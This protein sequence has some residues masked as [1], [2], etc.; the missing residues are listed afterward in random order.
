MLLHLGQKLMPL[1]LLVKSGTCLVIFMVSLVVLLIAIKLFLSGFIHHLIFLFE[2]KL[3]FFTY[4]SCT[5]A[6]IL[7]SFITFSSFKCPYIQGF[8]FWKC[9]V[10][11]HP[12]FILLFHLDIFLLHLFFCCSNVTH[13]FNVFSRELQGL[14]IIAI[15]KTRKLATADYEV[16]RRSYN[17]V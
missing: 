6:F 11:F 3:L 5:A 1:N 8:F 14:Q 4:C 7:M 15:Y 2:H 13:I 16:W 10:G 17:Y 12:F 9:M